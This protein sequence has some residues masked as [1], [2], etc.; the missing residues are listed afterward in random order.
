MTKNKA[1]KQA[2]REH[3]TQTGE[4][5]TKALHEL[6]NTTVWELGEDG[7][8]WFIEGTTNLPIA[9]IALKHWIKTTV[10]EHY[11]EYLENFTTPMFHHETRENWYWQ[12]LHPQYPNDES[13]LK[14][15]PQNQQPTF[16]GIHITI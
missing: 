10:P 6:E 12:P 3:I 14:H 11:T 2:L 13:I 5:Y 7:D 8:S 16:K 1:K 4:S 9:L 15:T